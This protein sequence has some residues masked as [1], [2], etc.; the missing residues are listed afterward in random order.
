MRVTHCFSLMFPCVS[1]AESQRWDVCVCV[2]CLRDEITNE[3]HAA[4]RLQ[5]PFKQNETSSS[6]RWLLFSSSLQTKRL[7]ED[8]LAR[9]TRNAQPARTSDG[10]HG[11]GPQRT[12]ED[13]TSGDSFH[14]ETLNTQGSCDWFYLLVSSVGDTALMDSFHPEETSFCFHFVF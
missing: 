8:L 6:R 11:D 7:P 3:Q 5:P 9:G 13:G 10:R 2:C 4:K 14:W 12:D 1:S